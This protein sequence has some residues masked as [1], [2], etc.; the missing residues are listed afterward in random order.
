VLVS[1]FTSLEAQDV[2]SV[3]VFPNPTQNMLHIHTGN[4]GAV[5]AKITDM[6][7]KT[8]IGQRIFQEA[9]FSLD[10]NDLAKGVYILSLE[11]EKGLVIRKIIKE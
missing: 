6:T 8:V 9:Q 11:N 1:G 7:G 2:F 3:A 4:A 10:L 5:I